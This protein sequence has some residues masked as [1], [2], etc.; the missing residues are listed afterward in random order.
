V[1]GRTGP[2]TPALRAVV[3]DLG[4]VCIDWDPRYLYRQLFA[5]D[6]AAMERFLAEVCTQEWNAEQDSGRSWAEA[7]ETLS[8]EHPEARDL[9]EA[10]RDRW[11]EMLGG[12]IDGTVE[13][14]DELRAGG[15]PIYA[16]S[17]WSVETF[18]L[19]R[20]R[21]AFL[22]WFEGIVISGVEGIRK[23]DPR[24]F[25]LLMDRY[26]LRPETTV[27]VDDVAENVAAAEALG[28]V[29]RVFRDGGALRRDLHRL[30]LLAG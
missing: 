10:F 28:M 5:G 7:V 30:G 24:I 13:V 3:F 15:T 27:F 18:P 25:R 1:S 17:N 23:P 12:A 2:G 21:F 22:D 20:P 29:G 16:L 11:S 19:A 9:I 4:G 14:L 26:G 8:R 6:E